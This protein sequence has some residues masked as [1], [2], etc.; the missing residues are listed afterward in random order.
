MF[1]K[2]S[3]GYVFGL[4]EFMATKV[5]PRGAYFAA[6]WRVSSSEPRTYGQWLQVKKM[7]RVPESAKS[8]S[9]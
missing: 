8:A 1:S 6:V 7:T 5:T 4:L 2:E 3:S 9:E